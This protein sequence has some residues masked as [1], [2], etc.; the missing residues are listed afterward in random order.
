MTRHEP[1]RGLADREAKGFDA[2]GPGARQVRER[3]A[4]QRI[5]LL[6]SWPALEAEW[7]RVPAHDRV[8]DSTVRV[9][10]SL[11]TRPSAGSP[12]LR[13][14]V[15]T[16]VPHWLLAGHLSQEERLIDMVAQCRVMAPSARLAMLG[17]FKDRGRAE[18]WV[19]RGCTVYMSETSSV[20]RVLFTLSVA[21]TLDLQIVDHGLYLRWR[22]SLPDSPNLTPRQ[23][24][25]LKLISAGCTNDEIAGELFLTRHTVEFHIRHLLQKLGARNRTEAAEQAHILGL[26]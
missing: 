9:H 4:Q 23:Q 26:C 14:H 16:A 19:R 15:R 8:D 2:V 6:G 3:P 20:D 22:R 1:A 17:S 10:D 18:S 21:G 5:F 13:R 25:V 12:H 24:Q 7:P 11:I